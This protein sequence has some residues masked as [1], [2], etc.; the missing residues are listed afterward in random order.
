[1][2]DLLKSKKGDMAIT[3]IAMVF[4][5]MGIGMIITEYL[6]VNG[7]NDHLETGLNRAVNLSIKEAMYDSF[8]QDY[9][10]KLDTD[11]AKSKFYAYLHEDLALDSQLEKHQSGQ[12]KY[13]YRIEIK[14]IEIDGENAKMKVKAV[15]SVPCFFMGLSDWQ[16]P[17]NV[18]SRNMRVDGR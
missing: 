16:L 18:G 15:A 3:V 6:K 1:M 5:V 4:I 7:I 14:S 9:L 17:V 12:T 2:K 8:R 10:N 13:V 11:V